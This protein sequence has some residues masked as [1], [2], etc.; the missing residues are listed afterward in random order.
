[1]NTV[2]SSTLLR[3]VWSFWGGT[4]WALEPP[5]TIEFATL[6][7]WLDQ[8]LRQAWTYY[9]WP[10]VLAVERRYYR[11][12]WATMGPILD[13]AGS[14]ILDTNG[15]YMLEPEVYDAGDEV[16]YPATDKYYVCLANG[17]VTRPADADGVLRTNWAELA[18]NYL[19][20]PWT[21]STAYDVRD[22]VLN[23]DND[24][25][26]ECIVAHTSALEAI[27]FEAVYWGLLTPFRRYVAWEQ[28]YEQPIGE[29]LGVF[30]KD[31]R[32]YGRLTSFP[33]VRTQEGV[34]VHSV[35]SKVWLKWRLRCPRLT[36][37]PYS[38]TR[39]YAA[40]EQCYFERADGR[41][42]WY[43]C[44]LPTAAGWSPETNPANWSVL[45]IPA[46]FEDFL[47][48]GCLASAHAADKEWMRATEQERHALAFLDDQVGQ[49]MDEDDT[50][51]RSEVCAR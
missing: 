1:M 51:R 30:D 27:G 12:F 25:V 41:G 23:P 19:A 31:P 37:A 3:Q 5:D 15:E 32:Q 50:D 42:D 28:I 16:F 6:R 36:G 38:A 40:R 48:K 8:R 34:E 17:T 9:A 24:Q 14:P 45:E 4:D 44:W 47:L 49:L 2:D 29:P 22:R 10:E 7:T 43:A 35:V 11:P 13:E 39:E 26:Y 46:R 20:D 21:P 18:D 33:F